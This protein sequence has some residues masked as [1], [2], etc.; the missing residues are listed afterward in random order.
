MCPLTE[1]SCAQISAETSMIS[2]HRKMELLYAQVEMEIPDNDDSI[3]ME[4]T[5][6]FPPFQISV[7][8]FYVGSTIF[9]IIES[10]GLFQPEHGNFR[11]PSKPL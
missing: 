4:I 5:P 11:Q 9:T 7:L 1:P 3:G 2:E 6:P 8:I 10:L